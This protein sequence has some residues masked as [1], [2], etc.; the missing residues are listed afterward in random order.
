MIERGL[1][2]TCVLSGQLLLVP[3]VVA[4]R[5]V[6]ERQSER[7]AAEP[8]A[9]LNELLISVGLAVAVGLALRAL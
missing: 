6:I 5:L 1:I 3:L 8:L 2:A 4:P 9:Y 7:A